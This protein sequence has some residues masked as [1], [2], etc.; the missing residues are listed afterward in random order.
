MKYNI[1]PCTTGTSTTSHTQ[2]NFEQKIE[3]FRK[4]SFAQV[5]KYPA[6]GQ[7]VY[8]GVSEFQ[9]GK[10]K[11]DTKFINKTVMLKIRRKK[12]CLLLGL[13]FDFSL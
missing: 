4:F 9:T 10:N 11:Y 8:R 13:F 6:I 7:L 1:H 12:G 3:S 2:E 5:N